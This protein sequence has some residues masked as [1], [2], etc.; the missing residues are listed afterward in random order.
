MKKRIV[1]AVLTIFSVCALSACSIQ[2]ID[3]LYSL[4]QPSQE[5]LQLQKLIDGE[6]AA[7]SEYSAPTVGSLRQSVQLTDLDGDGINEALAFFTRDESPKLCIYRKNTEGYAEALS[8]A[9]DGTSCG[10]VEYADLDGDGFSEIMI[11]WKTG[12]DMKLL[13]AY[14]VKNWASTVLLTTS[15]T[16]FQMGDLNMD[17]T[18]DLAALKFEEGAGSVE[19]YSLEKDGEIIQSSAILSASISRVERLRVGEYS[20]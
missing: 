6:I 4:P 17:G 12:S 7:G 9:G 2:E 14:S 3:E 10:R 15:C 16:D 11:S 19:V 20:R 1:L 5:Y 8:I 18:T 13:K